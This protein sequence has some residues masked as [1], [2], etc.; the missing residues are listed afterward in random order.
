MSLLLKAL[1]K[2]EEEKQQAEG[3]APAGQE[4][5]APPAAPA[6]GAAG[7]AGGGF[8]LSGGPAGGASKLGSALG[9]SQEARKIVVAHEEEPP[10]HDASAEAL[11]AASRRS[12][13]KNLVT[14]GVVVVVAGAGWYAWQEYGQQFLPGQEVAETEAVEE[15]APATATAEADAT[16]L[17]LSEPIYDIQ[18]SISLTSAN[19][20]GSGEGDDDIQGQVAEVV[21][22]I[23]ESQLD[24][25]RAFIEEQQR[26]I[27]QQANLEEVA[28]REIEE[29]LSQEFDPNAARQYGAFDDMVAQLELIS[30]QPLALKGGDQ[31]VKPAGS[32]LQELLDRSSSLEVQAAQIALDATGNGGNGSDKAAA[33]EA[34]PMVLAKSETDLKAVFEDAVASYRAGDLNHAEKSFRTVIAAEPKNT[35]ALV[36]LAKVHQSRGNLR[37]AVAT[38]LKAAD[39]SPNDPVVISELVSLQSSSSDPLV[40][41]SRIQSLLSSNPNPDIQARLRFLLGNSFAKQGNWYK[42][43]ESFMMAHS[44]DQSNPDIAYNL[45][46]I[47]DYLNDPDNAVR[48]YRTALS[49]AAANP[50]SFDLQVARDRIEQLSR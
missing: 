27:A 49:S 12:M 24:R 14:L 43:R 37:I 9:A 4:G 16:L 31:F 45:A 36:G 30:Q 41:E 48:M 44:L 28:E 47:L 13:V 21:T 22:N 18:E 46:V 11:V 19:I 23:I 35:S 29:V 34:K 17:P 7:D 2:S 40:S 26:I 42:A 50:S 1:E 5:A 15:A 39:I 25:Q 10:E 8:K 6:A 32:D 33:A 38:L 3:D 20:S